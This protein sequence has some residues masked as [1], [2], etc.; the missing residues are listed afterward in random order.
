M[1]GAMPGGWLAKARTCGRTC[2]PL[3]Q[4]RAQLQSQTGQVALHLC[5][6]VPLTRLA[7]LPR[8]G[9]GPTPQLQMRCC[10]ALITESRRANTSP[11]WVPPLCASGQEASRP[12]S[13]LE[14]SPTTLEALDFI[15]WVVLGWGWVEMIWREKPEGKKA[16][17]HFL[18]TLVLLVYSCRRLCH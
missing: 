17:S 13:L 18:T 5:C 2:R 11:V 12:V 15:G 1:P 8:P 4:Q 16:G 14:V 3:L 6:S 10:A 9:I 7:L